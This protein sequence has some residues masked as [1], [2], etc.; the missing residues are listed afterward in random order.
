MVSDGYLKYEEAKVHRSA[1]MQDFQDNKKKKCRLAVIWDFL[2]AKFV[3]CYPC[4]RHYI[5]FY[6]HSPAILHFFELRKYHKITKNQNGRIDGHFAIVCS[7]KLIR[8]LADIAEHICLI[9]RRFDGFFFISSL[10]AIVIKGSM[11]WRSK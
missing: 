10:V 3:M 4:V 9:K 1:I 6:I 11:I 2:S 8:T 5:L 7:Q